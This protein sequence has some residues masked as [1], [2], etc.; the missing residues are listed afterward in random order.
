MLLYYCT[1]ILL[2]YGTTILLYYY[3]TTLLYYHTTILP[4]YYTT[5]LHYYTSILLYHYVLYTKRYVLLYTMYY[6]LCIRP[7]F[8]LRVS[9]QEVWLSQIL[10]FKGWKSSVSRES[11][12]KFAPRI[13]SRKI[14]S[15]KI[16][17][18]L[19]EEALRRLR[20]EPLGPTAPGLWRPHTVHIYIYV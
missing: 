2:Y 18:T 9:F 14:L 5:L 4:Y 7:I 15:M 8:V 13:L 3:T 1:T 16:A 17:R 10:M 20:F 12:G 6:I 11:P 19:Y